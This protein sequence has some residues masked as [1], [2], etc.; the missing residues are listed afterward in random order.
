MV[1]SVAS[2]TFQNSH[3]MR[4]YNPRSH[5]EDVEMEPTDEINHLNNP[6]LANPEDRGNRNTPKKNNP[7]GNLKMESSHV[8]TNK[9]KKLFEIINYETVPTTSDK[10]LPV[11]SVVDKSKKKAKISIV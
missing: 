4:N 3:G 2:E 6:D 9:N 1:F 8:S 11:Y 10:R 5:Y 7:S